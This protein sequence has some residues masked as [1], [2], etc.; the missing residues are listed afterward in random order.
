MFYLFWVV[1]FLAIFLFRMID[2]RFRILQRFAAAQLLPEIIP[3]LSRERWRW[4]NILL[5]GVFVFSVLALARPQ[6]G[7][8]WQEV[9]R[10][11]LDILMV[12]DTSKSML[13][14]DVKPNRLE[15][16]K[17]AIKDLLKKLKGDRV[18]LIAFAGDAFMVCPL[19]VDYAGFM[20]SLNDLDVRTVGR[21]GTN[22]SRAIEEA[23]RDYGATRNEYKA[24]ILV[25]DGDDLEGDALAAA[26]KAKDKG[27]RIYSIGIGTPEGEL[28]QFAN[29]R[30]ETEFLKDS[31]GNFVKSRLNENLLQQIA[32]TTGGM[33]VRSGG[34]DFGLD[35]IYE[36]ELT[37]LPIGSLRE[38]K[39]DIEQ[40]MKKHYHER[41]QI[42][43]AVAVILLLIE[44]CLPTRKTRSVA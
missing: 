29:E 12:V 28:I 24:V 13:T 38:E 20:L 8:E 10:R 2:R 19:T 11:G 6:W 16:T 15:R 37:K 40:K 34:V 21:G 14:A 33:Y 41:F 32:L 42:P 1:M 7:F 43:L 31:A 17:L 44:T 23:I 18:G 3:G 35:F 39:R 5:V 30:G 9:K 27:I 22:L 25:T 36:H 26:R 4:K